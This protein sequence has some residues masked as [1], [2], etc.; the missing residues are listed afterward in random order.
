MATHK[1]KQNLFRFSDFSL[2]THFYSFFHINM[3]AEFD[4]VIIMLLDNETK[5]SE[6]CLYISILS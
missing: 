5:K 2:F 3:I 4:K 1:N 6:I